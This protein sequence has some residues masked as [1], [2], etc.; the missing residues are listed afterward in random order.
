MKPMSKDATTPKAPPKDAN[1]V[2]LSKV[3]REKKATNKGRASTLKSI[4]NAASN[5]DKAIQKTDAKSDDKMTVTQ[6][7]Y[8]VSDKYFLLLKPFL[9]SLPDPELVTPAKELHSTVLP[10]AIERR[11]KEEALAYLTSDAK[12]PKAATHGFKLKTTV[13]TV[14]SSAE[15]KALVQETDKKIKESEKLITKNM[16]KVKEMEIEAT[17]LDVL[18]ETISSS[19]KFAKI[20]VRY[21]KA[22][23]KTK[24]S[25]T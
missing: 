15:F 7:Q 23:N 5:K 20:L 6:K 17:K 22:Y 2:F 10:T 11:Q 1:A 3:R 4:T 13:S 16:I 25:Q 12:P 19:V 14:K 24:S 21:F 8:E 9:E 18:K